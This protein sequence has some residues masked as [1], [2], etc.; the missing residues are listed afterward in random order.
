MELELELLSPFVGVEPTLEVA[1]V[2]LSTLA[3]KS[4][5][6]EWFRLL[7]SACFSNPFN[8]GKLGLGNLINFGVV[9]VFWVNFFASFY[10]CSTTFL[11]SVLWANSIRPNNDWTPNI[12][13]SAFTSS[14][15]PFVKA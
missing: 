2:L 7:F 15:N 3:F 10:L 5:L 8:L 6:P 14:F 9:I 13:I 12:L 11:S 4:Y 1:F